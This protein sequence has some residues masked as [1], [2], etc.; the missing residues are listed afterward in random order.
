MV[1]WFLQKPFT[2]YNCL[3]KLYLF[4]SEISGWIEVDVRS[5]VDF[6]LENT[7]LQIKTS[8]GMIDIW[9]K[10][11][12]ESG[13]GAGSIMLQSY[14]FTDYEVAIDYCMSEYITNNFNIIDITRGY[15]SYLRLQK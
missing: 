15:F 9:L 10:F 3:A 13:I 8:D 11:Y 6:D 1:L 5:N 14:G 12:D 2:D 4:S 7:P